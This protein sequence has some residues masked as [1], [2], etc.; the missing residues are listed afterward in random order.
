M[1]HFI[2]HKDGSEPRTHREGWESSCPRAPEGL[3]GGSAGLEEG[4]D[5]RH[6]RGMRVGTARCSGMGQSTVWAVH[7]R[8]RRRR[9]AWG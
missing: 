8:Q 4:H 3:G 7:G 6:G 2:K 9:G 1:G 5:W